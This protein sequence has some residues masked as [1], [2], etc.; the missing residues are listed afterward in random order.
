MGDVAEGRER[1]GQ[2]GQG[3]FPSF[4]SLTPPV[5]RAGSTLKVRR[6]AQSFA[7]DSSSSA[8]PRLPSVHAKP[9]L[10]NCAA[11]P[12]A[13]RERA[14]RAGVQGKPTSFKFRT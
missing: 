7:P 2:G 11:R 8:P 13:G 1:L 6:K 14:A 4:T 5:P 3:P 10:W 12:W 9:G